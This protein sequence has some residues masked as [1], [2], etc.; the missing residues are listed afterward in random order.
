MGWF[1]KI[2]LELPKMTRKVM[3]EFRIDEIKAVEIAEKLLDTFYNRK[4]F[5]KNYSMP[6]YI[7]PRNLVK[8]SKE[9]A[10]YLT[11]VIAIDYMTDAEKL[12]R[13]SRGAYE[14]CPES[15]KPENIVRMGDRTLRAF[16]R[17]LGARFSTTG[18]S[19]W[20]KISTI[21]LNKYDG[22]PRNTTRQSLTIKEIKKKLDEFP[23]LRGNKLSNFYIRAM[24]ENELFK[25][26]NFDEL[27]V[28]VDIQIARFTIYTGVLKLLSHRFEGCVHEN[29]VRGLIE[30]AW[31]TVAKKINTYPWKLDEPMWTIG[32]KLCTRRKCYICPVE[33]LCDKTKG[34]KFREAI[35]IWEQV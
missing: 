18:V 21:L 33:E 14:V 6:E 5:F 32:S 13:N 7:L 9:H 11:Y 20:K 24:G 16:V 1:E 2:G 19:T 23:Y 28:P 26:S 34:V 35:A 12:W 17:R 29:P 3:V 31:R 4:G 30:E 22:D 15:F 8:G 27:D 25:I 10:L